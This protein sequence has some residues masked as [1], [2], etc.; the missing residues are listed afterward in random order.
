[1]LLTKYILFLL[2]KAVSPALMKPPQPKKIPEPKKAPEPAPR[3]LHPIR[4]KKEVPI[5]QKQEEPLKSSSSDAGDTQDTIKAN[6]VK[7]VSRVATDSFSTLRLRWHL[8]RF[9]RI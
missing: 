8:F 9:A 2:Q 3:D 4:E 5:K 6:T 1:M 7:E